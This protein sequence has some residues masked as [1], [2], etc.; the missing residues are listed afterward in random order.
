MASSRSRRSTRKVGMKSAKTM[1]SVVRRASM[2]ASKAKSA[3]KAATKAA[4]KAV[5][6]SKSVSASKAASASKSASA[7]ASAVIWPRATASRASL[8][9]RNVSCCRL[10]C[11]PT[12]RMTLAALIWKI[13]EK[14]RMTD[15]IRPAVPA[16]F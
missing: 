5:S 1:R 11:G 16:C 9:R 15:K 2:A 4:S 10:S 8:R 14:S 12:E 13:T 6:A 3:S 7:A